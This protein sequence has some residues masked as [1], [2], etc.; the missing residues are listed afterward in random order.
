MTDADLVLA[1]AIDACAVRETA[2]R[3]VMHRPSGHE[4][5]LAP[6]GLGCFSD[7]GSQS[8]SNTRVVRDGFQMFL[9]PKH[10]IAAGAASAQVQH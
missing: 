5:M 2:R 10:P 7:A 8:S 3:L 4:R 1:H 6:L 9:V